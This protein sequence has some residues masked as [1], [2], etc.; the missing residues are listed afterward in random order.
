[1]RGVVL[2][3]KYSRSRLERGKFIFLDVVLVV[4]FSSAPILGDCGRFLGLLVRGL[5]ALTSLHIL[6]CF[7]LPTVFYDRD[8]SGWQVGPCLYNLMFSEGVFFSKLRSS[9]KLLFSR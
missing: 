8:H 2:V 4:R 5:A 7:S 6:T 3:L 9:L 1:M